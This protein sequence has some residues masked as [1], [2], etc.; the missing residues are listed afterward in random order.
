MKTLGRA[1]M[2]ILVILAIIIIVVLLWQSARI[3][4]PILENFTWKVYS[5]IILVGVILV[6]LS[7]V[8]SLKRS[9]LPPIMIIAYIL[10]LLLFLLSACVLL[11]HD[12]YILLLVGFFL[13]GLGVVPIAAIACLFHPGEWYYIIPILVIFISAGFFR[14]YVGKSLTR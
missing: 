2:S 9:M 11:N 10:G 5:P 1:L 13:C 14:W 8:P 12:H 4:S 6:L 7:L 3:V